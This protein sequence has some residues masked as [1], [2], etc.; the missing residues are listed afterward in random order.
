MTTAAG[1]LIR[2]PVSIQ[3]ELWQVVRSAM[4]LSREER[5]EV[6]AAFVGVGQAFRGT[7]HPAADAVTSLLSAVGQVI[8]QVDHAGFPRT[9]N[10]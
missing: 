1:Q 2:L 4:G 5:A 8:T 3:D 6:L 7:N 10:I 9:E